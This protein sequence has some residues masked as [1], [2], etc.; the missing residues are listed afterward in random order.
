M[1]HTFEHYLNVK[2]AF[3]GKSAPFDSNT[4]GLLADWL[5]KEELRH[6]N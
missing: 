5:L 2:D 4:I 3:T 6:E 1:G